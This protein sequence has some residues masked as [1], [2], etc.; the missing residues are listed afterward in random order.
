MFYLY[1]KTHTT[2]GLKYLGFTSKNPNTYLGSGKYWLSHLAKH[3]K[4]ITTEILFESEDMSQIKEKGLYYSNLWNVVSSKEFANMAPE[5]GTGGSTMT[6]KKHTAETIQKMRESKTGKTFSESHRKNL[7]EAAKGKRFKE[8][9]NF[10]GKSHSNESKD[11]MSASL[12]GKIRTEEF[13]EHLSKMYLGKPKLRITCPH[14]GKEGG[15]PQIKRYHN[16][17]CKHKGE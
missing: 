11:K 10:Y 6:G 2:T 8:N 1:L 9:N 13:K 7:S 17:N 5:E 14:C 4:Q 16:D 15:L 3:G 12:V